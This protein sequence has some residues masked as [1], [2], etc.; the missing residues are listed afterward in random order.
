MEESRGIPLIFLLFFSN[1]SQNLLMKKPITGIFRLLF[2][3]FH[4]FLQNEASSRVVLRI[5]GRY[6][7]I[8]EFTEGVSDPQPTP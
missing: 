8:L 5:Q 1:K 3:N 2:P 7:V 6:E 4:H